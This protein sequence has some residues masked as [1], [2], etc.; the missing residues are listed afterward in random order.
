MG[1][2]LTVALASLD[3]Y[4][5]ISYDA[6]VLS[7][8]VILCNPMAPLCMG[9]SKQ[10]YRSGLPCPSPGDFSNPGMEPATPESLGLQADSLPS[11]ALKK[12][13]SYDESVSH[14]VMFNSLQL[15]GS[16]QPRD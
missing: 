13:I 9:F 1:K 7:C 2:S 6:C 10:E 15:H 12:P 5:C 4:M 8:S 3:F 16:S 11:E 14:S